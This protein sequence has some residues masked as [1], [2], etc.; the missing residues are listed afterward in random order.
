MRSLLAVLGLS[1]VLALQG[2]SSLRAGPELPEVDL[3]GLDTA[4]DWLTV[5]KAYS[6]AHANDAERVRIRNDYISNATAAIDVRFLA[7]L[8]SLSVGRSVMQAASQESVLAL[9]VAGTI[10]KSVAAKTNIASAIALISGSQAIIDSVYF[11]N[12]T[13]DAIA[14][15]MVAARREA[16]IDVLEAM[17]APASVTDLDAA[18]NAV[19]AYQDAGSFKKAIAQ[20]HQDASVR[21]ANATLVIQGMTVVRNVPENLTRANDDLKRSLTKKLSGWAAF[22]PDQVRNVLLDIGV[23]PKGIPDTLNKRV[24]ILQT[25]IRRA[26]TDGRV[27]EIQRSMTNRNLFP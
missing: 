24:E 26:D 16:F 25:Q 14:A 15:Q 1:T 22:S 12:Q 11:E 18:R 27:V 17:Q 5:R 23:S 2:C 21:A 13:T 19:L 9:G 10:A 7:Y 6:T 20:V 4:T 8:R 3:K